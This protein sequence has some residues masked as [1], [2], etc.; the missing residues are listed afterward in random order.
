VLE[1]FGG[2]SLAETRDNLD[3]YRLRLAGMAAPATVP[4]AGH[5]AEEATPDSAA[6]DATP[7]ST[8]G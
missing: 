4:D 6:A 7:G 2:D 5:G 1:K 3:R 8:G